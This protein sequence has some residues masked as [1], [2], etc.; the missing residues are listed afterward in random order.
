MRRKECALSGRVIATADADHGFYRSREYREQVNSQAKH[1]IRLNEGT[2]ANGMGARE[3]FG[4]QNKD[5]VINMA[6]IAT[7]QPGTPATSS[8]LGSRKV[9]T[10]I[11]TTEIANRSSWE[12][13]GVVR[14]QRPEPRK[15]LIVENIATLGN[16]KNAPPARPTRK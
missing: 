6:T 1:K 5:Y 2:V 7:P 15:T 16:Y 3:V 4:M 11:K 13:L 8:R 10:G 14:D 12:N 9:S